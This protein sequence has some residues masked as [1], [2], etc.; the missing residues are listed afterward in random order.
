MTE[1]PVNFGRKKSGR[2]KTTNM[3]CMVSCDTEVTEKTPVTVQEY[4]KNPGAQNF[5]NYIYIIGDP[6]DKEAELLKQKGEV[7]VTAAE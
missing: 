2:K 4:L 1:A 3:S 6:E 7:T 5:A